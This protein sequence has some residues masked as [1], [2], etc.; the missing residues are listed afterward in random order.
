MAL[1]SSPI[2]PRYVFWIMGGV[3]AVAAFAIVIY[4]LAYGPHAADCDSILV[5]TTILD[6][7]KK[8]SRL[9]STTDYDLDSIRQTG[10]DPAAGNVSCEAKVYGLFN[11]APYSSAPLTYTVTRNADGNIG[12]TVAG[13]SGLTFP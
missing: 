1:T 6:L 8:N 4:A 13:I 5:K 9:P 7:V 11:N 12:V 2:M 3:A 10:G